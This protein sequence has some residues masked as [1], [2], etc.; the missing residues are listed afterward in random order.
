MEA[1]HA[2]CKQYR[3]FSSGFLRHKVTW[4]ANHLAYGEP[5]AL[6]GGTA[7][8]LLCKARK[9]FTNPIISSINKAVAQ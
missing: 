3:S 7:A 6:L 1:E 9:C 4:A 8:T 2:F 5:F